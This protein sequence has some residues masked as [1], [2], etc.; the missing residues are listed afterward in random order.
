MIYGL[1]TIQ[2]CSENGHPIGIYLFKIKNGKPRTM[3]EKT[4]TICL[5]LINTVFLVAFEQIL[6]IVP[7][8]VKTSTRI[9]ILE[10]CAI[11]KKTS[12]FAK[13]ITAATSLHA[14]ILLFSA[15]AGV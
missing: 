5:K 14:A 10:L 7:V 9:F 11:F 13:S 12:D 6:H 3:F 8:T 15:C 2:R 4:R 1:E